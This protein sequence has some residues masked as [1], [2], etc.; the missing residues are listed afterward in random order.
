MGAPEDVQKALAAGLAAQVG[1]RQ[2]AGDDQR[3]GQPDLRSSRW[4][5]R[6]EINSYS[7][8]YPLALKPI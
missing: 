2:R 8:T 6:Y 7:R 1:W 4:Q 5:F 3:P